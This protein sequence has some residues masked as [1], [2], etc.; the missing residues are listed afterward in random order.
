MSTAISEFYL[1]RALT[2]HDKDLQLGAMSKS[3]QAQVKKTIRTGKSLSVWLPAD[4]VESLN[5][6][7]AD[8]RPSTSITAV[9]KTSLEDFLSQAGYYKAASKKE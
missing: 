4:L 7:V 1:I 9:V 3:A 2:R 5:R 8:T 6:F